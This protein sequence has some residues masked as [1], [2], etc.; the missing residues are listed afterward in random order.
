MTNADPA[1]FLV[2]PT[3]EEMSTAAAA[4]VVSLINQ[5]VAEAGLFTLVLS[6]GSTPQR[7]YRQLAE[8]YARRLPWEQIHLF[9]GDERCVPSMHPDSNFHMVFDALISAVRIP[10]ENVHRISGEN[11]ADEKDAAALAAAYEQELRRFAHKVGL[12]STL[13][14]DLLL[15][16]MGEDGHTASLFPGSP[17]LNET[18]LWVA[19][20]QAPATYSV[21]HRVTMTLPLIN[22]A[23]RVFVLAT[24]AAKRPLIQMIQQDAEQAARI[25]PV[26]QVKPVHPLTWFLDEA[27]A[28][29][30][31]PAPRNHTSEGN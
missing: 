28:P 14:F 29:P 24:G 22:Q 23:Q 10:Y 13:S 3:I 9:W 21:T 26:A 7:L 31:A 2:F 5:T 12:G 11:V 20:A 18:Q 16:G 19:A 1:H 27:A 6:G 25:Y 8:H 30:A 15:L 4:A 17:V